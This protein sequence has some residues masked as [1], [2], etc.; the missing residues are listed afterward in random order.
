M[1]GGDAF[2]IA[3][4]LTSLL[5]GVGY[6]AYMVMGYA[7]PEIVR[8]DQSQVA[9]PGFGYPAVSGADEA[10]NRLKGRLEEGKRASKYVARMQGT[11]NSLASA[12]AQQVGATSC[13][14]LADR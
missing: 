13:M 3:N 14:A 7:S 12:L 2:D 5:V 6:D 9:C 11:P 10:N 4:V 8:C 1:Q